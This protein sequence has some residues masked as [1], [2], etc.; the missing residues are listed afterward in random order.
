MFL[1]RAESF[2]CTRLEPRSHFCERQFPPGNWEVSI[3]C[4]QISTQ[5]EFESGKLQCN[6]TK[7]AVFYMRKKKKRALQTTLSKNP[8]SPQLSS[9]THSLTHEMDV[10]N[11]LCLFLSYPV[12]ALPRIEKCSSDKLNIFA[13]SSKQ[14]ALVHCFFVVLSVCGEK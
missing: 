6:R 7:S 2:S 9:L 4:S 13:E 12:N 1:R 5:I 8:F 10:H 11:S 3:C 14:L